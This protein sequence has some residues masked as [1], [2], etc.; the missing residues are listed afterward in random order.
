VN[1]PRVETMAR[2]QAGT[3][4]SGGVTYIPGRRRTRVRETPVPDHATETGV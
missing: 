4:H 3:M 2:P 1:A